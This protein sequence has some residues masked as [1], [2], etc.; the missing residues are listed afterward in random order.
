MPPLT[1]L[2]TSD[3]HNHIGLEQAGRLRTLRLEHQALLLDSG[4]AIW[5]GN[6]FVKP[7]AEQAIRRMNEAGYTALGMGNREFFF[8]S[9]G[10]IVKTVEARFP[11]LCANLL[12]VKGELGHI[13]RWTPLD[14]PQ[15]QRVGV[16]G[17]MPMMIRPGTLAEDVSDVRFITPARATREAVAALR[18][19]CDWLICLSHAG[20]AINGPLA[21][22][23]SALDLILGG[24]DHVDAFEV[25]NG[26]TISH[27]GPYG[28]HV[29][30]LRSEQPRR[31]SGFTREDITLP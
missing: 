18:D 3:F 4:D 21:R 29:S 2:H 24:H 22:D 15:G 5:A 27:V 1:I 20:M 13:Q 10:L 16:F 11:V 23:F 26:V 31:P 30:L 14:S 7:G 19:D 28:K 8:R 6:V 12:P 9:A 17:L 25:V